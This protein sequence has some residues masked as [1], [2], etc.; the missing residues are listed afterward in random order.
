V[1]GLPTNN[2]VGLNQLPLQYLSLGQLLNQNIYSAAA[3]SAG[4]PVPYPG[5]NGSVLQALRPYPQY[6]TIEDIQAMCKNTYCTLEFFRF[7]RISIMA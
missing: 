4:I 6:Q 7:S 3:Q 1:H 2:L 5:F